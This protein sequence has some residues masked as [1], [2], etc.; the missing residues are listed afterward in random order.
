MNTMEKFEWIYIL[1][2]WIKQHNREIRMNKRLNEMN[3]ADKFE[4]IYF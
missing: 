2:Y 1:Y 3:I 4:W